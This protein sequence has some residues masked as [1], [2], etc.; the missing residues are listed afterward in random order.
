MGLALES[1][2]RTSAASTISYLDN[3]VVFVGSSFGDSQLVRLLQQPVGDSQP[4]SFLELVEAFANLGP[5]VDMAVVD[6]D[7]QGQGQVV[8]CS[9]VQ[10]DGSLRIVRNGIGMI[11][12]ATV[13]LSGMLECSHAVRSCA[14]DHD[15]SGFSALRFMVMSLAPLQG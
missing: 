8:T 10:A 7:R 6:L 4:P 14:H 13:E 3:G 12:Q 11:E 2:G 1:L 5:I 15:L 9:G